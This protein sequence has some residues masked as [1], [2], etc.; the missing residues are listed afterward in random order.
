MSNG[1]VWSLTRLGLGSAESGM[2]AYFRATLMAVCIA[3]AAACNLN[4]F[5]HAPRTIFEDSNIYR[6]S[7]EVTAAILSDDKDAIIE[8]SSQ[9]AIES[10][11]FD[12]GVDKILD[13]IPNAPSTS[14][15]LI[16][17]ELIYGIGDD[18][19]KTGYRLSY[20]LTNGEEIYLLMLA[21][22]EFDAGCCELV[23]FD[24]QP[25]AH[26]P[27]RDY[28]L[29]FEGKGPLHYL[30][31]ALLCIMPVFLVVTAIFCFRNA[32]VRRKWLWIPFILIGLWGIQFNWTT[33]AMSQ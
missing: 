7:D 25:L 19:Q 18:N 14:A 3:L 17:A 12:Q 4:V 5:E 27:S 26:L 23:R 10:E 24:V 6:L 30:V 8:R 9:I 20:E 16:F 15:N 22:A 11:G 31:F 33:G 13:L 29:S 2:R 32:N 28:D 21:V 1:R